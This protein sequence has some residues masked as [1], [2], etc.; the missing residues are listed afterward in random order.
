[1]KIQ[2]SNEY[3]VSTYDPNASDTE[4]TGYALMKELNGSKVKFTIL[5]LTKAISM[6]Y[7]KEVCRNN[8]KIMSHYMMTG[9]LQEMLVN[10]KFSAGQKKP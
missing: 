8:E 1:M 7:T 6:K 2:S 3:H 5:C 4:T 9:D 10:S